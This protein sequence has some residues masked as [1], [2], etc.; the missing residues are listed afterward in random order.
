[1]SPSEPEDSREARTDRS[2]RLTLERFAWEAIGEEAMRAG[3]TIDE[4]VAFSVLYYLAD[5]DSGRIS[6]QIARSPCGRPSTRRS[7]GDGEALPAHVER[8]TDLR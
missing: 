7:E 4:L 1:M 5:I 8:I 3:S 2:V 6:R